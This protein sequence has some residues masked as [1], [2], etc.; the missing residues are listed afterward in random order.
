M[1]RDTKNYNFGS[2]DDS[3]PL[4]DLLADVRP[5]V[6][7]MSSE[8]TQQIFRDALKQSAVTPKRSA[9]F[10][11]RLWFAAAL[12]AGALAGAALLAVLV[13]KSP[14]AGGRTKAHEKYVHVDNLN[15]HDSR[16]PAPLHNRDEKTLPLPVVSGSRT[17]RNDPV[18]PRLKHSNRSRMA[19]STPR[20]P[21]LM[22]ANLEFVR[23]DAL[24]SSVL[25]ESAPDTYYVFR[26]GQQTAP[27]S[28]N[29]ALLQYDVQ[30]S[31]M[32]VEPVRFVVHVSQGNERGFAKASTAILDDAGQMQRRFCTVSDDSESQNV[33]ATTTI[34]DHTSTEG[35]L[36]LTVRFTLDRSGKGE[37]KQ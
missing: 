12:P 8:R 32:R 27:G 19:R 17:V 4:G 33:T 24:V 36:A 35:R 22:I 26:D 5:P 31:A 30:D 6:E 14:D 28:A 18:L 29:V 23:N 1:P 25:S 37:T 21:M 15:P 34:G 13:H 3:D 9:R 20:R 7:A 2:G 11:G 10:G 16:Q